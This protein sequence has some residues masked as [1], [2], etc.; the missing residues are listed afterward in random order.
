M[1]LNNISLVLFLVMPVI[2]NASVSH[3][4]A[5]ESIKFS[6]LIIGGKTV[7]LCTQGKQG[8]L[9][10]LSYRYGALGKVEIDF[11]A[12]PG[13]TNRFFA[14]V[15]PT[16]SGASV[17][18]VWFNR[19]KVRYLITECIGGNCKNNAGLA[20]MSGG[21]FIMNKYCAFAVPGNHLAWFAQDL[22]NFGSNPKDSRSSTNLLRIEGD[23]V[24][25]VEDIY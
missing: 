2:S 23:E 9:D 17:N 11:T 19:G 16:G 6:C 22:V 3:C 20:V 7:S 14:T 10:S 13:N 4:L 1:L 24:N 15:S 12:K 8:A 5:N 21:R 25:G 18:Q